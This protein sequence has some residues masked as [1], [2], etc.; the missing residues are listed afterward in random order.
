MAEQIYTC[1]LWK[2]PQWIA[3]MCPEVARGKPPRKWFWTGQRMGS[4]PQVSKRSSGTCHPL[5]THDR[6]VHYWNLD[7]MIW[8]HIGVVL[9][10]YNFIILWFLKDCSLS[11]T[12]S[13]SVWERLYHVDRVLLWGRIKE[14]RRN[15]KWLLWSD[16]NSHSL[17]PFGEKDVEDSGWKL[18]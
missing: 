7:S 9:W 14:W 3:W 11:E 18:I 12:H 5:G 15:I 13:E 17:F 10:F 4:S 1:S 16:Y 6:S 8:T 2:I